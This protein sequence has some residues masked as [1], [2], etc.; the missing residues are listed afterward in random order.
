MTH[1]EYENEVNKIRG[2]FLAQWIFIEN[3]ISFTI[4]RYFC[5]DRDKW[6]DF[7]TFIDGQKNFDEKIKILEHILKSDSGS[8]NISETTQL[9]ESIRRTFKLRKHF[10]HHI[11]KFEQ[12]KYNPDL[13]IFVAP[14]KYGVNNDQREVGNYSVKNHGAS[15]SE[16]KKIISTF[17]NILKP[18][19]PHL[20]SS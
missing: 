8:S 20:Y 1:E 9:L 5:G 17:L 6:N 19:Y 10:A 14:G 2:E 11:T 4:T 16:L 12:E 15:I 18:A 13:I 7:D 3:L